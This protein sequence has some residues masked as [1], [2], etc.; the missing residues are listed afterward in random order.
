MRP[1]SAASYDLLQRAGFFTLLVSNDQRDRFHAAV[2]WRIVHSA[3]L[4]VVTAIT[5]EDLAKQAKVDLWH[6]SPSD[7]APVFT[8]INE[9]LTAVNAAFVTTDSGDVPLT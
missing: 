9:S 3:S 7:L 5:P 8:V 4:D 1:L 6:V 2:M